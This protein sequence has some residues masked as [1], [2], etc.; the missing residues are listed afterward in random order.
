MR[1]GKV[2]N[3]ARKRIQSI[4]PCTQ[5]CL[6]SGRHMSP[7][8]HLTAFFHRVTNPS[9]R[10]PELSRLQ[11]TFMPRLVPMLVSEVIVYHSLLRELLSVVAKQSN[12]NR[13]IEPSH[14]ERPA[15]YDIT[16][17]SRYHHHRIVIVHLDLKPFQNLPFQSLSK[18]PDHWITRR[19]LFF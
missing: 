14:I 5:H 16:P 6:T 19:V 18:A 12:C 13:T 9:S 3:L 1:I 4:N 10:L 7:S 8:P 11:P 15:K 2:G 17:R